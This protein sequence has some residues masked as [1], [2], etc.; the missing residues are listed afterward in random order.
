MNFDTLDTV[1]DDIIDLTDGDLDK[2][3]TIIT[4]GKKYANITSDK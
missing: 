1:I 2:I 3:D 4:G